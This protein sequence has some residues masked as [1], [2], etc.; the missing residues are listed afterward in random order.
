MALPGGRL[1]TVMPLD[2][3][4]RDVVCTVFQDCIDQLSILGGII[5]NF[6]DKPS[7]L[8]SV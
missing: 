2:L 8:D 1:L 6:A 7:A 3:V 4:Q 5:P